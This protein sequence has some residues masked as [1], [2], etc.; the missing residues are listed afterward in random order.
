LPWIVPRYSPTTTE[1]EQPNGEKVR[2]GGGYGGA[3]KAAVVEFDI[4]LDGRAATG[5]ED[6]TCAD[7]A[8]L[9]IHRMGVL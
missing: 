7:G 2:S 5:I 6:L 3:T 4:G 1:T 9:G 8:N